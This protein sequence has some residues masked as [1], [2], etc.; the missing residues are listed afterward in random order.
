MAVANEEKLLLGDAGHIYT[1]YLFPRSIYFFVSRE[2]VRQNANLHC[3]RTV[4][5]IG[6]L[7]NNVK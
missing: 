4:K 1:L 6:T 3:W 2:Y 5:Y 7:G